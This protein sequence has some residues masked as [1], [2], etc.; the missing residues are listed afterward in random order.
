MLIS[1]Q[2]RPKRSRRLRNRSSS[3]EESAGR[4]P[5]SIDAEDGLILR[6][7]PSLVVGFTSSS[8]SLKRSA[9]LFSFSFS[10]SPRTASETTS[11]KRSARFL[12]AVSCSLE[13]IDATGAGF[14]EI[15]PPNLAALAASLS[16]PAPAFKVTAVTVGAFG[17]VASLVAEPLAAVAGVP[18]PLVL[19]SLLPLLL[20]GGAGAAL[21]T[22]A[23]A[24][25]AA[26]SGTTTAAAAAAG[27]A[28][29]GGGSVVKGSV[30]GTGG[31]GA[32]LPSTS[33]SLASR[34]DF[35]AEAGSVIP[36]SFSSF[37]SSGT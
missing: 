17:V 4:F 8:V 16:P 37:L 34:S 6:T 31:R 22:E 33:V 21:V 10:S 26:A 25:A 5:D 12:R 36:R 24:A 14:E 23:G 11:P 19:L 35:F 18:L 1:L 9:R 28:L 29:L 27:V 30:G 3:S 15:D 2:V 7:R 13:P 32:A 20:A